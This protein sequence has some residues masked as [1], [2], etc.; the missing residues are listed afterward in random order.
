MLT[1]NN[2]SMLKI[3]LGTW[4][5]LKAIKL[6]PKRNQQFFR[7][8][9]IQTAAARE[10]AEIFGKAERTVSWTYDSPILDRPVEMELE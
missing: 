9:I 10:E 5:L 7:D 3:R 4:V 1:Q 6:Y 8:L 2:W